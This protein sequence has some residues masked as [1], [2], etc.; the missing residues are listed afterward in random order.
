MNATALAQQALYP[1]PPLL[2]TG[3][4]FSGTTWIGRQISDAFNMSYFGEPWNPR[5]GIVGYQLP[6]SNHYTYVTEANEDHYLPNLRR[7]ASMQPALNW[8]RWVARPGKARREIGEFRRRLT[9]RSTGQRPLWKDPVAIL[10]SG[11]IIR[12]FDASVVLVVRDPVSFVASALK[13]RGSKQPSGL[14]WLKDDTAFLAAY[15]DRFG[16]LLQRIDTSTFDPVARWAGVWDL[17]MTVALLELEPHGINVMVLRYEDC[18]ASPGQMLTS[19]S[20]QLA[21]PML[22]DPDAVVRRHRNTHSHRCLASPF[23]PLKSADRSGKTLTGEQQQLVRAITGALAS[24]W[25]PSVG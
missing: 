9:A 11:W 17:L 20:Q 3:V 22:A 15:G 10:S 7:L 23:D 16:D 5:T 13:R 24:R 4:P 18:L 19:I 8:S 12:T 6:F 21:M 1:L 14:G 25:Y 2:V